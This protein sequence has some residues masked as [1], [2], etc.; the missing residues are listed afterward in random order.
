MTQHSIKLTQRRDVRQILLR[1]QAR[2]DVG[3]RF[4]RN[5]GTTRSGGQFAGLQK[6]TVWLNATVIPGKDISLWRQDPCGAHMYWYDYGKTDSLYGWE[7]DHIVPVAHGGTDALSNLQ[8]LHWKNNRS[9][10]DSAGGNY[11]VVTYKAI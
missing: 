7:V 6:A 2:N 5:R 1:A 11:C 8:A 3:A 9:K 10:A 4:L